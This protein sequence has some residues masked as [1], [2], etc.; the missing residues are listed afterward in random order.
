MSDI[1]KEQYDSSVVFIGHIARDEKQEQSWQKLS[2]PYIAKI[3]RITC[4][5][6]HVPTDSNC[7]NL[8]SNHITESTYYK[9]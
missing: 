6:V 2:E 1:T 3:Q 9:K 5:L 8:N 4:E 7:E